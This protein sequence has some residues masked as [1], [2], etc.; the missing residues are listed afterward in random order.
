MTHY[1]QRKV[2][3]NGPAVRSGGT[4]GRSTGTAG[5]STDAAVTIGQGGI[6]KKRLSVPPM[7]SVRAVVAALLVLTVAVTPACGKRSNVSVI[8]A[9]STSVQP[10]AELLAEEF[11]RL[12]TDIAI[13]IQGGGSSA[14]ITAVLSDTAD[15]G[16]SSRRLKDSEQHLWFVEIA[17]D[18][19]A[20]IVH[21]DNPVRN[22]SMEQ[23]RGIYAGRITKWSEVGGGDANIHVISREE[24][25]G[26]KSAFEELV[27]GTD[28]IDPR[29]IIQDSN[30]AVI[31]LV[32]GDKNSIGFISL[33]LVSE[34][35]RPISLDGVTASPENVLN[36]AYRL[37]REFLFVT[38]A[39]PS[40]RVKQ[41]IDFTLSPEGRSILT[42]EGLIPP[43]G[44]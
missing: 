22:L 39:E 1:N 36:G 10:Y 23:L 20:V 41:F 21:P 35:V 26:T 38:S 44:A 27:M 42:G 12:H 6:A 2:N 24:G 29:S 25:S 28:L 7:N 3:S 33:G 18:G 37:Y 5:R 30:G 13:D 16:M 19:L 40:G 43:K 15:V 34:A 32:S 31:Q 8:I 17:R 9:G 11:E 4:V 14:G